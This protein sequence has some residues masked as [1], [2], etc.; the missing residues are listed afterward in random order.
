L[1]AYYCTTLMST[2]RGSRMRNFG[3]HAGTAA[4]GL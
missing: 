2:G 1:N 3:N 4:Y